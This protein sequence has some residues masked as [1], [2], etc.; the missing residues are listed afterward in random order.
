MW[1]S[2]LALGASTLACGRANAAPTPSEVPELP[3]FAPT[4]PPRRRVL[5]ISASSRLD[6][7]PGPADFLTAFQIVYDAGARGAFTSWT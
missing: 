1:L 7:A 3:T 2:A 5:S 6:P 4:S